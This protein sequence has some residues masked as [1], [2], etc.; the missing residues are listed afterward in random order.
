ME[1]IYRK[2]SL[3]RVKSPDELNDYVR[4]TNPAIWMVLIAVVILLIGVVV[5]AATGQLRTL[6]TTSAVTVDGELQCLIKATDIDSVKPGMKV[7]VD[8]KTYTIK[9][10]DPSPI[11]VDENVME[12][13]KYLGDLQEGEFVYIACA[14]C[15]D[16]PDDG[17][18]KADIETQSVSPLYFITN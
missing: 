3:D 14:D 2:K 7:Y 15:K 12:Y 1:Q 11:Q 9:E 17:I 5:W 4:V 13:T 16:L 10:I 18:F 8:D 6:V